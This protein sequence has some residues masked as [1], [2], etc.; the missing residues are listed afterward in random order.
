LRRKA[1]LEIDPGIFQE[2]IMKHA[3]LPLL[4][5]A[6]LLAGCTNTLLVPITGDKTAEVVFGG[7]GPELASRGGVKI[8][9]AGMELN[10]KSK[11]INYIFDF[12]V[13]DG[14][15][16]RSILVEDV[17]EQEPAPNVLAED[18]HPHLTADR[19][20]HFVSPSKMADDPDLAWISNIEATMRVYRFTVVTADGDQV[21]LYQPTQFSAYLKTAIRKTLGL[22][23]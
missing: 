10:P 14:R 6:I 11:A 5:A 19:H 23:Y 15:A 3:P 9:R 16:P 4:A 22:T 18:S 2:F 12:I 1:N 13:S 21:V 20:W 17:S 8:T 7:S